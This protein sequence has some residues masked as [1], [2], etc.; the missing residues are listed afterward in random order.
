MSNIFFMMN[1][2]SPLCASMYRCIYSLS[3]GLHNK[4][5]F[6]Y[7]EQNHNVVC[8]FTFNN[9]KTPFNYRFVENS[10]VMD[11]NGIRN[12]EKQKL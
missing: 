5:I 11:E 4:S 1:V 10:I 3:D 8:V 9:K 2:Q 6:F 7:F 12:C